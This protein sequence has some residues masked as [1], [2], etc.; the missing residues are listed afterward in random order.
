MMAKRPRRMR[1]EAV[2]IARHRRIQNL[3]QQKET[4]QRDVIAD[5]Q[6]LV[7]RQTESLD[8]LATEVGR[9]TSRE[10]DLRVALREAQDQLLRRDDEIQ[11][12]IYD[13]Q[14]TLA[15][16]LY[17]DATN[18]PASSREGSEG[19]VPGKIIRHQQLIRRIRE[20]VRG[21]VPRDAVVLVVSESD[22]E[23]LNLYGRQSWHFPQRED[24]AYTG[25]YPP[26]D[27]A[28]IVQ[29]EALRAKGGDYLLFPAP[30]IGWLKPRVRFKQH[31]ERYY[32]VVVN[33][34]DTC[35]I[36]ALRESP[37]LNNVA[38]WTKF[39]EVIAEFR[40]RF[41]REPAILDWNTNFNLAARFSHH[42]VFSPVAADDLNLPYLDSSIDISA[43]SYSDPAYV[44]EAHR[45]AKAAV[46]GFNGEPAG[47]EAGVNLEVDWKLATTTTVSPM[48]SIVIPTYNGIAYVN[49]CLTALRET[50]PR[51]LR[52]EIIIVD[53]ASSEETRA[54]LKRWAKLD[55]RLRIVRNRRNSGFITSCN[56]GAKVATGEILILL[57]DDTLPQRGWLPPLLQIFDNRPDAG[58]AGGKLVYPDGRLQEAG[59]VIFSDCSGANFGKFDHNTDA[60]VYNYV[61]EVDYCSGA[62]LATKRSLFL[63]LGGF[64]AYYWP[65]YYEDADYCFRL[66]DNGYRV[67]YQPESTII[68]LEGA[69]SGTNLNSGAKRYQAVNRAKFAQRW[70]E[71]LK[72]QPDPPS[73][74]DLA[75][76]HAL[77][78]RDRW[79]GTREDR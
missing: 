20:V 72:R 42:T 6:Q 65:A 77:A 79:K 33:Q 5:L 15:G 63:E 29:L 13:I 9:I 51:N 67:Y 47:E 69:T 14:V 24:G 73:R 21:M 70:D 46:I 25:Y 8:A 66:R 55:K 57:N 1:P 41:G 78:V 23:L 31:L 59:G 36:F 22:N 11:S 27:A 7:A 32:R 18:A 44:R 50:L 56:R 38:W 12:T 4:F 40:G 58:A 76:W 37:A 2:F 3:T 71:E 28:A 60:P 74:F 17:R 64:D 30:T 49:T 62:L 54:G 52:V 19:L 53:D 16:K 61:R 34:E 43:V 26:T 45:V 10:A 39:E 35:L 75:T 48:T 68:H